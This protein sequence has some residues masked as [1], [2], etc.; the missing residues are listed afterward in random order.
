MN[1]VDRLKSLTSQT[2]VGMYS[3]LFHPEFMG[4]IAGL[5]SG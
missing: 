4:T 5:I 3:G 2:S 1:D